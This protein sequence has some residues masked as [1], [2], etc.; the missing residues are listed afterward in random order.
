MRMGGRGRASLSTMQREG[1]LPRGRGVLGLW[2]LVLCLLRT[3]FI[4]CFVLVP[5]VRSLSPIHKN[6][7]TPFRG[8]R[9]VYTQV[10]QITCSVVFVGPHRFTFSSPSPPRLCSPSS[11][12]PP[13]SPS[14]PSS[15]P[16]A[17][18]PPR[19]PRPPAPRRTAPA[20]PPAPPAWS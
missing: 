14:P 11:P 9:E 1:I 8:R 20:S 13:Y 18:A 3:T 5:S 2:V 17:A 19:S 7:H 16:P 12:L 10:T 4:L 6:K 15:P